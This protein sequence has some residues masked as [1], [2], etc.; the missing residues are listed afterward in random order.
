MKIRMLK[1]WN[2]HK[3]NSVVEVFDPLARDWI[4]N[5]VAE[6]FGEPRSVQVERA[7]E[8]SQEVEQAVVS[9]KRRMPRRG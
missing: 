9:E 4:N 2:W 1:D 8:H 6:E 3:A 7:V 5:G